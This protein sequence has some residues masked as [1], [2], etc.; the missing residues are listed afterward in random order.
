MQLIAS[1]NWSQEGADAIAQRCKQRKVGK[2]ALVRELQQLAD[3]RLGS[4][5]G[6]EHDAGNYADS[7]SEPLLARH[8]Q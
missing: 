5:L 7:S 8:L 4:R 1:L 2:A 3:N 6:F